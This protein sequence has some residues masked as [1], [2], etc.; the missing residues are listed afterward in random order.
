[1]VKKSYHLKL[2]IYRVAVSTYDPPR[3]EILGVSHYELVLT[4]LYIHR[5][6]TLAV[7]VTSIQPKPIIEERSFSILHLSPCVKYPIHAHRNRSDRV[8][9][10]LR[11]VRIANMGLFYFGD[12]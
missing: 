5:R 7:I 9:I 10:Y 11:I 2:K 4:N 12:I 1:M 3:Q 8:M 6:I